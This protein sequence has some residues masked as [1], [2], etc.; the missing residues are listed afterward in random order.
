[1]L[2]FERNSIASENGGKSIYAYVQQQ[3]YAGES[4]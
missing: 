1:M 4:C 3:N 2:A